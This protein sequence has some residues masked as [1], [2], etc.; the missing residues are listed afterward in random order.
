VVI[1]LG[2]LGCTVR[3]N[4][5]YSASGAACEVPTTT[6][7]VTNPTGDQI[8]RVVVNYHEDKNVRMEVFASA[9]DTASANPMNDLV[10]GN[11]AIFDF[12]GAPIAVQPDWYVVTRFLDGCAYY[13]S[14]GTGRH[15]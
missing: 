9:S 5:V 8:L 10:I 1:A 6:S 4:K 7:V 13:V 15:T 12:T 14:T 3:A 11:P 2:V